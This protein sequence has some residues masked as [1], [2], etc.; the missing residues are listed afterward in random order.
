MIKL[1]DKPKN[2]VINDAQNLYIFYNILSNYRIQRR[3]YRV[4]YQEITESFKRYIES[5]E[6]DE[7]EAVNLDLGT[8]G[9]GIQPIEK[10]SDCVEL[11]QAFHLFYHINDRLLYTTTTFLLLSM[12]KKYQL[13][14]YMKN[15]ARHFLTESFR[16]HFYVH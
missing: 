3:I 14:N 16:S 11:L 4:L 15:F 1:V 2:E 7:V 8:N 13:E 5:L 6:F 12:A 9:S 10:Y